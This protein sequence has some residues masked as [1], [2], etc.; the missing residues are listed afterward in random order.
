M[1]NL[2]TLNYIYHQSYYK[3][4][5]FLNTGD[6]QCSEDPCLL[7][8]VYRS[9]P[10]HS[11]RSP[12]HTQ[13]TS[14]SLSWRLLPDTCSHRHRGYRLLPTGPGC[15]PRDKLTPQGGQELRESGRKI[16]SWQYEMSAWHGVVWGLT[17]EWWMRSLIPAVKGV[18]GCG[19]KTR[20]GWGVSD[21]RSVTG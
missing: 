8:H 6:I 9:V 16:L 17:G 3:W 2:Q 11:P 14:I 4:G 1:C 13:L 10:T 15:D 18:S 7:Y 12:T 20:V 19:G 5:S 21:I